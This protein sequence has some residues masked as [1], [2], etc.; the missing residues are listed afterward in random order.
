MFIHS[1]TNAAWLGGLG[2]PMTMPNGGDSGPNGV[3]G[4]HG[5]EMEGSPLHDLGPHWGPRQQAWHGEC[6]CMLCWVGM[7][8]GCGWALAKVNKALCQ[9]S[10]TLL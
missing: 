5:Q 3:Q 7:V 9:L 2:S 10:E 8:P 6:F 1:G 4:E